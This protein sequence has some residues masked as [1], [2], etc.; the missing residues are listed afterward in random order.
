M[1]SIKFP[2]LFCAV[3]LALTAVSSA[4]PAAAE[5]VRG[6][7]GTLTVECRNIGEGLVDVDITATPDAGRGLI[8]GMAGTV[9]STAGNFKPFTYAAN[10][11]ERTARTSVQLNVRGKT[12]GQY[13]ARVYGLGVTTDVDAFTL[14]P[15]SCSFPVY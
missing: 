3:T 14:V 2:G 1:T 12:P 7:G 13:T 4:L 10:S 15:A 11:P 5:T 6:N 8:L 9:A